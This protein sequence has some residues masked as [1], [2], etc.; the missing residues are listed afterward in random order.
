MGFPGTLLEFLCWLPLAAF[1]FFASNFTLL[2]GIER[3]GLFCVLLL[4]S[5]FLVALPVLLARRPALLGRVEQWPSPLIWTWTLAS[6]GLSAA[7]AVAYGFSANS[8]F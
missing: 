7:L 5:S 2:S 6:G 1:L 4:A 8:F 3:I